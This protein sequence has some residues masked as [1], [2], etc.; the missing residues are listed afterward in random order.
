MRFSVSDVGGPASELAVIGPNRER[1]QGP[2]KKN[3][4]HNFGSIGEIWQ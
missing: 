2:I 4:G 3:N 1:A